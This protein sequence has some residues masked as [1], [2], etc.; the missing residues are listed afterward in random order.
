MRTRGF[1]GGSSEQEEEINL[2]NVSINNGDGHLC[3]SKEEEGLKG[4]ENQT[5]TNNTC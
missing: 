4:A 3:N 5:V 1:S 2:K